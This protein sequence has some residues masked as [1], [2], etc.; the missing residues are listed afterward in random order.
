MTRQLFVGFLLL[1]TGL[2]SPSNGIDEKADRDPLHMLMV[3]AI[4]MITSVVIYVITQKLFQ[5][6]KTNQN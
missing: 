4:I 3:T 1:G 6:K 5:I 2:I